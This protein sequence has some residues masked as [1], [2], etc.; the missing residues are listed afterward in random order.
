MSLQGGS[1]V[2]SRIATRG[3]I[4]R[5]LDAS[6]PRPAAKLSAMLSTEQLEATDQR[7]GLFGC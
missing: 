7:G 1:L 5:V 6:M 2:D 4:R 3:H